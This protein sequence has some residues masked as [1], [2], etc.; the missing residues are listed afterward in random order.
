MSKLQPGAKVPAFELL[1][2]QNEL[3]SLKDFAGQQV[4]IYFYPAAQTP[5]CTKQAC[6]FRDNLSQLNKAGYSILGISPDKPAK[7]MAFKEQEKL[8]FP[9]LSDP[10]KTVLE[11][12][13]AFGEKQLYGKTVVGVIRSTLLVQVDK[14][15][16]G[17]VMAA[18]YGVKATGHVARLV[19][20]L[21]ISTA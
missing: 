17:V 1:N 12:F 10:S 3:V 5:G 6:D 19:K 21:E 13:G 15:G 16:Q 11:A 8:N 2:E 20:E 14:S 9:L 7:L 4:I 18:W